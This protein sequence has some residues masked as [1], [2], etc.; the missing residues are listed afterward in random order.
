M[1]IH[2]LFTKLSKHGLCGLFVTMLT[3][4]ILPSV[5]AQNSVF[6]S[7][8]AENDNGDGT[9]W[10][11]AK[12]TIAAGIT[13]TGGNGTVFVKAG[14]YAITAE[15]TIPDGVTVM[16]GYQQSSAGTDTSLRRL[17]GINSNWGNTSWCTIISGAGNHRI[18]TVNG[19]LDGCVARYGFTTTMGGGLLIDGGTACY[20]VLI[21]NDA[22]HDDEGT[23]EGG[24]AYVKN[25]GMLLNSVVTECRGDNGAG[26]SGED[27][28]LIN[29]TI[30]RNWP[31]QC[32]TVTDY[33]GNTYHTVQIGS[34]CWMKEN[35]RTTHYSDGT[36][37]PTN[38]GV[39][40]DYP[41][42]YY[43]N[44]N[45][46]NMVAYGLLYNWPAVMNGAVTSNANPS[47]VQGICPEG[48]HVP[49][50]N[51]WTQLTDFVSSRNAWWCSGNSSNI[52]KALATNSGWH[53]YTNS[54]YPCYIGYNQS[55][56][57]ATRF[58]AIPAGWKYDGTS[59]YD[60]NDYAYFWSTTQGSS[61]SY[62]RIFRL[63][64]S[65]STVYREN[66]SNRYG[67]SVRCIRDE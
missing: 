55:G 7:A 23:A 61:S 12:K 3:L 27:G 5:S 21:W 13:A 59:Y 18:A 35:L 40:S 64:Y 58:S 32:G 11:T 28:S 19:T 16:G 6:V 26:V 1:N 38:S 51:E 17:P 50:D 10:A 30:T 56:N 42:W 4:I 49:S 15:L 20:C 62:T 45:A 47:G 46:S 44:N 48:W 22:I 36:A 25:N 53:N 41:Y 37:I 9:T 52:A 57:N 31:S 2:F 14:N 60:I 29:N 63:N 66:Q 67:M 39:S 8:S 24:G 54:S 33:D 65:S 34:Q 43:P